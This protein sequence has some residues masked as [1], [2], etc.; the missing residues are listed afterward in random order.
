[1]TASWGSTSFRLEGVPE[2][3]SLV[4][5]EAAAD[6]EAQIV[7]VISLTFDGA[8]PTP[9]PVGTAVGPD[10][11]P[12]PRM[13]ATPEGVN[14]PPTPQRTPI[15]KPK[16][17]KKP[18]GGAPLPTNCLDCH[19]DRGGTRCGD[20]IWEA[21]HRAVFKCPAKATIEKGKM[22]DLMKDLLPQ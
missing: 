1:M 9:S 11:R 21:I 18:S 3:A 6:S 2:G 12:T 16:P 15:A 22:F 13:T 4:S 7:E 17:T 5:Y 10:P 20:P 8:P 14:P 19:G